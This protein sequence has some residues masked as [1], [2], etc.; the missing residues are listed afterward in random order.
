MQIIMRSILSPGFAAEAMKK[1]LLSGPQVAQVTKAMQNEQ[2]SR[3][4]VTAAVRKKIRGPPTWLHFWVAAAA[5]GAVLTA[6]NWQTKKIMEADTA[7]QSAQISNSASRIIISQMQME[8]E[9]H[10]VMWSLFLK[11]KVRLAYLI[12]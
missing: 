4:Q 11:G 8:R 9:L 12:A 2:L 5:G 6:F 1:E 7:T 10:G 3:T